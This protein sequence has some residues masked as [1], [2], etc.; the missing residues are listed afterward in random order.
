MFLPS[1]HGKNIGKKGLKNVINVHFYREVT[2]KNVQNVGYAFLLIF[3]N[4]SL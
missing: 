1:N 3:F 2:V 4:R